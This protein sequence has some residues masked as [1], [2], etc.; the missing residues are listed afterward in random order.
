MARFRWSDILKTG[1]KAVLDNLEGRLQDSDRDDRSRQDEGRDA[2]GR[3]APA[4]GDRPPRPAP[5]APKRGQDLDILVAR[6]GSEAQARAQ[7]LADGTTVRAERKLWKALELA[8]EHLNNQGPCGVTLRIAAG[9][10]PGRLRTGV[11][12]IPKI[13]APDSSLHILGGHDGAFSRRTPFASQTVLEVAQDRNAPVLQFERNS[14]LDRF[15]LSG[16]V[17]DCGPSNVYGA[18]DNLM[19]GQTG[20]YELLAFSYLEVEDLVVA[21]NVFANA[22]HRVAETLIRAASDGAEILV[23]NNIFLNNVMT[24]RAFSAKF[25]HQPARYVFEHNSFILNWP[26]NPDRSTSNPGALELGDKHSAGTVELRRNLFAFNVGGAIHAGFDREHGPEMV[27]EDNLFWG[28]G[29]LFELD[30]PGL[31]AVVGKFNRSRT[32]LPL[33]PDDLE[34][35]LE[36]QAAANVVLDPDLRVQILPFEGFDS[37]EAP[38]A[39][40]LGTEAPGTGAKGTGVGSGDLAADGLDDDAAASDPGSDKGPGG[41]DDFATGSEVALGGSLD[42]DAEGFDLGQGEVFGDE[43]FGDSASEDFG[44]GDFDTEDYDGDLDAF[45][46][47]FSHLDWD[48]G[49]DRSYQSRGFA[50]RLFLDANEVPLPRAEAAAHYGASPEHVERDD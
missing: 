32:Y 18:G 15:V 25:R 3:R 19:T 38:G 41:D 13:V 2:G 16:L 24:W 40:S 46:E 34:D 9:H 39:E 29:A 44:A 10:Y 45:D 12:Q 7:S 22:G 48:A 30:D 21:D 49:G 36:W 37:S 35:E 42:D 33:H 8:A 50:A 27:V 26:H 31:G 4:S 1:A 47:G 43:T 20:A 17:I 28:N 6:R 11:W 5:E 14:K 23:R